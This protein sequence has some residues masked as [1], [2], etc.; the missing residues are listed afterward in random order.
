MSPVNTLNRLLQVQDFDGAAIT[1]SLVTFNDGA[2]P[3]FRSLNISQDVANQFAAIAI[4][5]MSEYARL[6]VNNDLR[7]HQYS[8][9]YRPDTHE[10][11][12][13]GLQENE[14]GRILTEIPD[15]ADIPLVDPND[16]FIN[17]VRFYMLAIQLT[18]NSFQFFRKYSRSKE[19]TRS[20]NFF[21]RLM[22]ERYE[23]LIEPTFQFDDKFDVIVFGN[24][25]FSFNKS[26]FQHIF[27]FYEMMRESAEE[28]LRTISTTIPIANFARFERSCL[29]HLQKLAKLRNIASKPYLARVTMDDLRR[30][31]ARFNLPI[32]IVDEGGTEKL[33]FDENDKWTILNLL[34]DAYLGSEMTGIKYEANSKREI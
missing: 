21:I 27:R 34:D 23:C 16:N 30:T 17:D 20:S 4:N 5:F 31:I 24:F 15:P 32:Q 29:S 8:G 7:L 12:W 18:G 26:S 3:E 25:I 1:L 6:N 33:A 14:I 28:C 2:D 19:L 22:G 9:G 11:E 10:I 13:L